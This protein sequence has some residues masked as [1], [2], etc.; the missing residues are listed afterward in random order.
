MDEPGLRLPD[1]GLF[2]DNSETQVLQFS[3]SFLGLAEQV[4]VGNRAASGTTLV[5]DGN[6]LV[7]HWGP[8]LLTITDVIRRRGRTS[9]G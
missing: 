1:R 6:V 8:D 5:G 9:F 7:R 3:A 2:Q 4:D